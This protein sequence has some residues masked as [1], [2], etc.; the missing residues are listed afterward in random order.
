[1]SSNIRTTSRTKN[2]TIPFETVIVI[3]PDGG[4]GWV[5]VA[6][7][8]IC[9]M[10]I[11][12]S[13]Y[14]FGIFLDDI[15]STFDV[16]KTKIAVISSVLSGFYYLSGPF[17]CALT[18]TIGFRFV[19]MAGG[20]G[21]ALAIFITSQWTVLW[22]VFVTHG[23]CCGIAFGMVYVPSVLVIGFYFE[24]W[25][26]LATSLASTGSSVGI[27]A[28][29][30]VI[31]I[32]LD[33]FTWRFQFCCLAGMF[34]VVGLCAL[35]YK[36]LKSIKLEPPDNILPTI[37]SRG[38]AQE[39]EGMSLTSKFSRLTSY[40]NKAYPTAADF[41][42]ES[43]VLKE[44]SQETIGGSTSILNSNAVVS[45]SSLCSRLT[46]T[47]RGPFNCLQ[48]V[49]EEDEKAG[50]CPCIQ[51]C[52]C[53]RC[54]CYKRRK[55]PIARP[56]YRDDIFYGASLNKLP[57]YTSA[58]RGPS[59]V[60]SQSTRVI[61]YHLSVTRVAAQRDVRE[62]YSCCPYPVKRTLVT[63]LDVSILKS[64]SFLFLAI[65]GFFTTLGVYVP[66][67]YIVERAQQKGINS[68]NAYFLLSV[69]GMANAVGRIV[70]GVMASLPHFNA[71]LVSFLMVFSGGIA[72]LVSSVWH[73]YEWQIGFACVY[74]SSIACLSAMRTVVI[75]D[76]VKL[77]NLTTALGVTLVFQGIAAIISMPTVAVIISAMDDDY[78]AAFYFGGSVVT[79]G[80]IFL[81]P[82]QLMHY[83]GR[84][85]VV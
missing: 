66:F 57:Q 15:A 41:Y 54:I 47:S 48:P 85:N 71:L 78:D 16:P 2:E 62:K 42:R 10:I 84:R 11:D 1:M 17:V 52:N 8:F 24:R 53:S 61:D 74:G 40:H 81:I 26:A 25:R 77:E 34:I 27:I 43:N 18:N 30:A 6:A 14:T 35:T 56:M 20:F 44:L 7:A 65:S 21:A 55:E 29:P 50:C 4:W 58:T 45:R 46:K 32:A 33:G 75:V 49:A 60:A 76:L 37:E 39:G 72:T 22:P 59:S 5:I 31:K 64:R 9:N 83:K 36:P 67:V 80:A 73:V 12:G 63:M 79:L 28:F 51:R 69:M 70:I 68:K 3:P 38:T 82:I 23:F 19:G 13:L